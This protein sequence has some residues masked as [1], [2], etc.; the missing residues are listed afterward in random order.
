MNKV[1]PPDIYFGCDKAI[2]RQRE[3][4]K[5]KTFEMRSFHQR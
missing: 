3:R 2:L 5:Q 1:T 4:N